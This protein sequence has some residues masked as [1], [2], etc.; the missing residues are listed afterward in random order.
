MHSPVPESSS[1]GS[2]CLEMHLPVHRQFTA[3]G[4]TEKALGGWRC[5]HSHELSG[6]KYASAEDTYVWF[7]AKGLQTEITEVTE[8][9]GKENIR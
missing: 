5:G 7:C 6:E 9:Q 4:E 8:E 1:G 3:S 2:N